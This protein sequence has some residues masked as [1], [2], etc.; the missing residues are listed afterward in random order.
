MYP[1]TDDSSG[2][3]EEQ[4]ERLLRTN[5]PDGVFSL[6]QWYT[7][8][9]EFKQSV[10]RYV[11]KTRRNV[12]NDRWEN[13]KQGARCKAKDCEW[14]IYCVVENPIKKWM[15]KRFDDKHTCH[16]VGRYDLIRSPVV[17]NLFLENNRRDPHMTAPEIKDEMKRRYNI[18]ITPSLAQSARKKDFWYVRSWMQWTICKT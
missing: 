10:I 8:G 9:K 2:D 5:L 12:V 18:I 3:E 11:L 17:A 7:N 1:A 15:V 13:T 4:A 6:K 14:L 16:P